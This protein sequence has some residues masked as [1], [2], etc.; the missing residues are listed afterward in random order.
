MG[1]Y[2]G[3]HVSAYHPWERKFIVVE[4]K[5]DPAQRREMFELCLSRVGGPSWISCD[6]EQKGHT[7]E[8]G[9]IQQESQAIRPT[10]AKTGTKLFGT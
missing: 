3:D 9:L 8:V 4:Q 7:S 5:K 10:L 6:I 2:L 1:L